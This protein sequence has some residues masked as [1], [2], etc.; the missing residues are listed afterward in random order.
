MKFSF[1]KPNKEKILIYQESFLKY[2]LKDNKTEILPSI[3]KKIYLHFVFISLL[4][5]PL[6]IL[7]LKKLRL[8]YSINF[9]EYVGPKIIITFLNNDIFFYKLKNYFKGIIFIAIQNGYRFK[10]DDLFGLN[11]KKKSLSCDYIFCFG[12]NVAKKYNHIFNSKIIIHGS[13]KNNLV[14]NKSQKKN[15]CLFISSYGLGGNDNEDLILPM[16]EEYCNKNNLVLK[17]LCRLQEQEEINYFNSFKFISN[18]N[19]IRNL[20][21]K[22]FYNSYKILD[23]SKISISMN[24]T[25][26]YENLAR[27]GRTLFINVKTRD[28]N[29]KSFLSF[30]WPKKFKNE[31]KFWLNSINK[32]KIFKRLDFLLNS[33]NS[34]WNLIHKRY[35]KQIMNV[36]KKNKKLNSIIKN[37]L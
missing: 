16:L 12:S 7:N 36:D 26:G 31:G 24:A 23:K 19:I 1:R 15:W 21:N 33:S 27:G 25:L 28:L 11:L 29:C 17:I 8:F 6:L 22:K 18:K 3:N 10:K 4:K 20:G 37:Y 34:K 35:I 14:K 30:G 9:I 5:N 2:Y 13:T 32:K